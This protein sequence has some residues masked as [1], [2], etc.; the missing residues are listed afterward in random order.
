[1][2]KGQFLL[3]P[4]NKKLANREKSKTNRYLDR[5]VTVTQFR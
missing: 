1:M 5:N 4:K 3:V 2:N